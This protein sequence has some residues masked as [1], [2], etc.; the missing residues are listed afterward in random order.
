MI[1]ISHRAALCVRVS[2]DKQTV[3]NQIA[4]L[5]K[6]AEQLRRIATTGLAVPRSVRI[7]LGSRSE[8]G[9][10]VDKAAAASVDSLKPGSNKGAAI[11]C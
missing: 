3:E 9:T 5:S 6:I 11:A 8:R 1:T 7:G 2:T 4:A 10:D